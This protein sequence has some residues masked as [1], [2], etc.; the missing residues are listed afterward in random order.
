MR[1]PPPFRGIDFDQSQDVL[2]VIVKLEGAD[3]NGHATY[4]QGEIERMMRHPDN[5]SRR[6]Y[7]YIELEKGQTKDGET[8]SAAC[9]NP[10]G[11][12]RERTGWI[13]HLLANDF[14]QQG[15]ELKAAGRPKAEYEDRF[16]TALKHGCSAIKYFQPDGFTELIPTRAL[17]RLA[18]DELGRG[19]AER[20]GAGICLRSP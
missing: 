12:C 10:E 16:L 17:E 18:W 14:F 11:L 15:K 2:D 5:G 4:F 3:S 9:R 6:F 13:F 1:H 19:S 20:P 7:S 8:G